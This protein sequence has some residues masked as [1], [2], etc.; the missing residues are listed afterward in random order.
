M[1][2]LNYSLT[3]R[4]DILKIIP[5]DAFGT[6]LD[7]GC[8]TGILGAELKKR[9][10]KVIGI[11]IE[12]ELANEAGRR[13][14]LVYK[15]DAETQDFPI[16]NGSVDLVIFAD[17]IEHVK[18]PGG[19]LQKYLRLLKNGGYVVASIPNVQFY[20]V[21][22][23]LLRGEWAY[24]ERGIFDKTH[25]RFFTLKSILRLLKGCGLTVVKIKRNYRL[26]E[27]KCAYEKWAELLALG[28]FKN[29]FTFQYIILARKK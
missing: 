22:W 18:W 5:A 16:Q 29:F 28:I 13:L 9:K 27:S 11:E 24:R 7:V 6:V 3:P 4:E 1:R 10:A 12:E 26:F 14:D 8:A 15:G 19:F 2:K 20:Y 21:L 17:I 23:C 25:L